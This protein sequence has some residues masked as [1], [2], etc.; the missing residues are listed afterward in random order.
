MK[1][2]PDI[3]LNFDNFLSEII[4][5]STIQLLII[6]ERWETITLLNI[7][8]CLEELLANSI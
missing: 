8:H 7:T 5:R 4:L 3:V 6:S 2:L 1:I